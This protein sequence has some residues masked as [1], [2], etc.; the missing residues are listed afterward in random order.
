M[1]LRGLGFRLRFLGFT[2]LGFWGLRLRR[3]AP[4]LRMLLLLR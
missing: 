3:K 1:G 4:G 2:S